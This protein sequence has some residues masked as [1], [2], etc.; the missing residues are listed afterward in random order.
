MD[1]NGIVLCSFINIINIVLTSYWIIIWTWNVTYK[2][3]MKYK[4]GTH[5]EEG[6]E[7]GRQIRWHSYHNEAVMQPM[8]ASDVRKI[9]HQV[10]IL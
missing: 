8:G 5:G 1:N 2:K 10:F 7:V 9:P 6:W 4:C 3:T